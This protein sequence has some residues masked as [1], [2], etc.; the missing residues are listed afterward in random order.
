MSTSIE[1]MLSWATRLHTP[2]GIS[3]GSAVF[4]LLTA[5]GPYTLQQA[6]PFPSK[7]PPRTGICTPT[8][9]MVPW[10]HPEST[11]QTTS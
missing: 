1:H 2:N 9:Y 11:T 7:L 8:Q 4:A 5:E 3:T 10:V 6:A